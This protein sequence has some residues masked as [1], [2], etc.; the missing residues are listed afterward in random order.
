MAH[1]DDLLCAGLGIP[2]VGGLPNLDEGPVFPRGRCQREQ[3]SVE[4]LVKANGHSNTS[5][6]EDL[7]LERGG[8]FI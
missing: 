6:Q 3:D 4:L 2:S 1:L 8:G 5:K 7:Q